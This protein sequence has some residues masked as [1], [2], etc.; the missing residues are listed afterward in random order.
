[1][2]CFLRASQTPRHWTV[3]VCCTVGL[4]VLPAEVASYNKFVVCCKREPKQEAREPVEVQKEVEVLELADS[5]EETTYIHPASKSRFGSQHKGVRYG[6]QQQ[7]QQLQQ[8]RVSGTT[9]LAYP[10]HC[11]RCDDIMNWQPD[12]SKV[13]ALC[14]ILLSLDSASQLQ[15]CRKRCHVRF[16]RS[17]EIDVSF[18]QKLCHCSK[19]HWPKSAVDAK[20][21]HN[22][23]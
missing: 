7:H 12:M 15:Q 1:M 23:L 22:M 16:S 19:T 21:S 5:A 17:S 6:Q 10:N 11:S 8:E 4:C 18:Q 20:F 14:W 2:V 13:S 3:A 9:L